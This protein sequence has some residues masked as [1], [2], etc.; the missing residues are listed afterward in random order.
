MAKKRSKEKR[1]SILQNIFHNKGFMQFMKR[2]LIFLFI[3]L[4][5]ALILKI[6]ID[7]SFDPDIPSALYIDFMAPL[8][9]LFAAL[10]FYIIAR[11]K[12]VHL[13]KLK[14]FNFLHLK[15]LLPLNLILFVAFFKLNVF[16]QD[17]P[18]YV[19]E[20]RIIFAIIW[21][22]L[23]IGLG[24]SLFFAF[25][26]PDYVIS[27]VKKFKKE[28]I[29]SVFIAILF[30]YTYL[31]FSRAWE[32]FSGIVGFLV[33]NMLKITYPNAI[34]SGGGSAPIL[35]AGG[36][37][38]KIFAPCSGIEGMTLFITLFIVMMMIE[39]RFINKTKA[40]SLLIV[41]TAGAFVVNILRVY[42]LFQVGI[43]VS[44]EFAIGFFHSNVGWIL[45]SL[46]F[47]G[48]EFFTYNWMRK[49]EVKKL[50]K[51]RL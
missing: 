37:S 9:I 40:F 43:I 8:I 25:F 12:L 7:F 15:I 24:L 29:V 42:A 1:N 41:G 18:Y 38:A 22:I 6:N 16:M 45:F 46:Y 11:H 48:F 23:A 26:R 2:T 49:R 10:V 32:F 33:F 36:F 39:W 20:N 4:L 14:P 31:Y 19:I 47:V 30:R 5:E 13:G 51:I 50:G 44:P 3:F 28:M 35:S 21:Y 17:N 27:F 34:S